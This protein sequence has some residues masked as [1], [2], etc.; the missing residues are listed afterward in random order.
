M[1]NSNEILSYSGYFSYEVTGK[2]INQLKA[3]RDSMN[4]QKS[5]YRKILTLMVE[6]LE[7]NYKYV[8][9]LNEQIIEKTDK[10][11]IFKITNNS[12]HFKLISGNPILGDDVKS[13]TRKI[14]LINSLEQKELKELYKI[15]MSEG[16]Y[17][18]KEGAGLGI[19]KMAKV[20]K[21]PIDYKIENIED[22]IY[23]YTIVITIPSQ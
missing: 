15:T 19:M 23:F 7:N 2:L 12:N 14:D 6:I 8:N 16:I 17:D 20:S 22:N 5:V 21:N 10:K 11:P 18:N 9:S 4:I 1:E 3:M 13:L